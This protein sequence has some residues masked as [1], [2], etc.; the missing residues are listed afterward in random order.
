MFSH[1]LACEL[2]KEAT[3]TISDLL[4]DGAVLFGIDPVFCTEFLLDGVETC[5]EKCQLSIKY[6]LISSQLP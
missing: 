6:D 4:V 5:D 1:L 3:G 2:L